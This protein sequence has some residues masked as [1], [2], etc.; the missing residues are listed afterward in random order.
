[1]TLGLQVRLDMILA[2]E[3]SDMASAV[4]A[5]ATANNRAPQ[6][7]VGIDGVESGVPPEVRPPCEGCLALCARRF[8]ILIGQFI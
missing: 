1:M 7:H 4:S 3:W 5:A 8:S 2:P 6:S